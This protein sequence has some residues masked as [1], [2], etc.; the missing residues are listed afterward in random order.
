MCFSLIGC[1]DGDS[2]NS[3]IA[4]SATNTSSPTDGN[5]GSGNPP[6]MQDPNSPPCS[7]LYDDRVCEVIRLT[8]EERANEG[9]AALG[10]DVN[11]SNLA[12]AH[13]ED[14]AANG[15]FSHTSPTYGT[16]NVR[17]DRFNLGGFSGENIAAGTRLT[18]E[19]V[20]E[21][22]MNSPGHR[23]NILNRNY[24]RIGVGIGLEER[25]FFYTQ[26]FTRR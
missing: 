25:T 16:F 19:Q 12:E 20:V 1:S 15:F 8:N 7:Q 23:A 10:V 9:L 3:S 24:N 26:C 6:P 17:A 13:S 5:S 21:N 4:S 18:P 22:W 14:M 11:C 2:S